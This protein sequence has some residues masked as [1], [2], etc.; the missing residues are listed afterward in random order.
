MR[1]MKLIQT[2]VFF[3]I[4]V[5]SLEAQFSPGVDWKKLESDHFILIFPGE[6]YEQAQDVLF[7]AEAVYRREMSDFGESR[8]SKWPL[9]LTTS[10]MESNG[11]V[12]LAPRKSVWFGTPAAGGLSSLDWYDLLALHETRHMVQMDHMNQGFIRFLYFFGGEL[13]LTAGIHLSVPSW[14]LEGDAVSAETEYSSGGRGRDPLFYDQMRVLALNED[15]SYQKFVNRSYK[16]FIPNQYAFGYF[17]ASYIKREYGDESWNRILRT[18][19]ILP[20]PAFGLYLGAK[21]V[22]GK[23]WT[24]LCQDMMKELKERWSKEQDSLI[25]I[26]NETVLARSQRIYAVYETIFADDSI[27]LARKI[28]LNEPP[29]LVKIDLRDGKEETLFRVSAEGGISSNGHMVVWSWIRPSALY[30]Y[31]SWSD[32]ILADVSSGKKIYLSRKERY[33]SPTFSRK[34]TQFAVVNWRSDLKAEIHILDSPT[35]ETLA[36]HPVPIEGFPAS[37]AWS[38]DDRTLYFTIQ[39]VKGRGIFSLD[40]ESKSFSMIQ[41]FS[42]ETVKGLQP[43]KNYLFYQSNLTG[44]ENIMALDLVSQKKYQVSSRPY[45]VRNLYL[46]SSESKIYYSDTKDLNGNTIVSQKLSPDLWRELSSDD[47]NSSPDKLKAEWTNNVL[48]EFSDTKD[49]Q[50]S[51]IQDY[52]LSKGKFNLHSWGISPNLETMTGLRFQVQSTD[53]METMNWAAGAEYEVNEKRWGSFFDLDWTQF[54]PEI[55]FR[56]NSIFKTIGDTDLWDVSSRLGLSFP[57]NLKRDSWYYFLNPG[58]S[59][60]IRAYLTEDGKEIDHYFPVNTNLSAYALL[61]GSIRSINP[62]WGL[63]QRAG[64]SM[65]PSGI[66][67]L[68]KVY[69]DTRIYTPGIFRNNSLTLNISLEEQSGHYSLSFPYAR[70]YESRTD[71]RTMKGSAQYDFPLF[72]S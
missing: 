31:K 11:F 49:I 47:N 69:T 24:I 33:I 6:I 9:I 64:S 8:E 7:K 46:S 5:A 3:F 43:W 57:M 26:D 72:L 54:Y 35:G 27:V 65:D 55:S 45:G 15:F 53:V 20:L 28:S 32:L 62:P 36:V 17:M 21:K 68:Y 25:L 13:G 67:D 58:F 66:N 44:Y 18:T 71:Y 23:S 40:L 29:V 16:H 42:M 52:S 2:W 10:G 1:L 19:S 39:G 70:G 63:W 51:D 38:Q 14:Y 59:S 56:N 34:G 37:L 60:G 61:P 30:H 50:I 48:P 22:T 4:A 12:T 41:D